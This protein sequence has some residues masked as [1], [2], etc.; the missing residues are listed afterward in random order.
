MKMY[1]QLECSA[2]EALGLQKHSTFYRFHM[3][4]PGAALWLT[5]SF[6][7]GCLCLAVERLWQLTHN[8]V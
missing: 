6:R 3:Q 1:G 4:N 7:A 2:R 5:H 8:C